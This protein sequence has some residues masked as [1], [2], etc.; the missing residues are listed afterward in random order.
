MNFINTQINKIT[1]MQ[2]TLKNKLE[3]AQENI[4][5]HEASKLIQKV[6]G[7]DFPIIEKEKISVRSSMPAMT[8]SG[9]SA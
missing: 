1:I 8:S 3:E 9:E 6:L 5:P 4:D 2:T 7:S